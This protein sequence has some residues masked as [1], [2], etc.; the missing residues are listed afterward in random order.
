M[1]CSDVELARMHVEALFVHDSNGRLLSVNEPEPLAPAPRFFLTRTTAANLWRVRHD[2]AADL[3]VE[4]EQL[5]ADEP[6]VDDWRV[7]PL[8]AEDYMRLLLQH[9]NLPAIVTGP[10]FTLAE[11][12]V[13][14]RAVTI[15]QANSELLE[16]YFDWLRRDM[17]VYAPIAVV[18]ADGAATAACYSS[19]LTAVA[20]EAGVGTEMPYRGRGY[21]SDVVRAWAAGVRASGRQPIY[22][23]TWTNKASQA[24][25]RKLGGVQFAVDFSII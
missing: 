18:V 5:A 7:P 19:R 17:D 21:A 6:A 24:V 3:A 15:T 20:A 16:R 8:H 4:L 9:D 23:T 10:T 1:S 25:A 22:N 11:Q 13:P 14:E 12:A 2:V